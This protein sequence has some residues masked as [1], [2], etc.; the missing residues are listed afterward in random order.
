[1]GVAE[2]EPA[3]SADPMDLFSFSAPERAMRPPER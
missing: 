2:I 3:A 1:V